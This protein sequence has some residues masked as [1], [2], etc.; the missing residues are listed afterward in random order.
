[1]NEL[2][3]ARIYL[4]EMK[5]TN[6]YNNND[7]N[8]PFYNRNENGDWEDLE[9]TPLSQP[10]ELPEVMRPQETAQSEQQTA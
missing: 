1:M 8:L 4:L 7:N 3:A 9:V 10:P 5:S 2:N 6:D